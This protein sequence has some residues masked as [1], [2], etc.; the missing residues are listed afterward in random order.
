MN[1]HVFAMCL[2]WMLICHVR[3]IC[4]VFDLDAVRMFGFDMMNL[5]IC[6][7]TVMG[8]RPRMV[9]PNCA[10]VTTIVLSMLPPLWR[11]HHIMEIY[12]VGP[13][14]PIPATIILLIQL[15]YLFGDICLWVDDL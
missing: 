5:L 8:G 15:C 4:H 13:V 10:K 7:T 11:G 14:K 1:H 2:T 9:S 3:L 6:T 12:P